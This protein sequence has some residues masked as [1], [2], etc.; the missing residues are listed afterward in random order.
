MKNEQGFTILELM[1][2]LSIV[3]ILLTIA[4]PSFQQSVRRAKETVLKQNLF[5]LR[6]VID[7]YRADRG[8]Y[9]PNLEDLKASGYLKSMP[10]DPLTKSSTTWQEIQDQAD[11]G[12][13]DAFSGSELVSLEGTAY[14]TW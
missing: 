2:V 8:K 3:A 11:G 14:N 13:F 10:I 7:Q 5:T 1:I 12:V 6:E 4:E 9:P